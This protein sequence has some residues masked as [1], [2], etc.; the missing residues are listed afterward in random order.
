MIFC[1]DTKT[2]S[3]DKSECNVNDYLKWVIVNILME[4]DMWSVNILTELDMWSGYLRGQ[5]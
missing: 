4:L 5:E 3:L 2:I 1:I